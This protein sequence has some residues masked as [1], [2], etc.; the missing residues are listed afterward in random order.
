MCNIISEPEKLY[1]EKQSRQE[2]RGERVGWRR[3]FCAGDMGKV[4]MS[5]PCSLP[6]FFPSFFPFAYKLLLSTYCIPGPGGVPNQWVI[7][8]CESKAWGTVGAWRRDSHPIW[9]GGEK[10]QGTEKHFHCISRFTVDKTSAFQGP[11]FCWR[12]SFLQG[13]LRMLG[14]QE[15]LRRKGHLSL[16]RL[17]PCFL[18]VWN[19]LSALE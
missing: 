14:L 6:P 19:Q 7:T 1:K 10:G 11:I 15:V 5:F 4:K 2:E 9:V 18:Q 13:I 8:E 16:L 3:Q 12:K 17:V